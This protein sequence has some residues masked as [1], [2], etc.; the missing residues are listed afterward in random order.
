[1]KTKTKTR[2]VRENNPANN[3]NDLYAEN[4]ELKEALSRQ[5]AFIKADEIS[6]HEIQYT[7]PKEKYPDL[8]EA[9]Q[10]SMD[11]VGVVFDKS[12]VFE[13]AIPDIFRGK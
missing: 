1:M 10:K 4:A 12:G 13:R 9:I 11:S 5:N 6:L 2:T 8:E 7:I 3:H